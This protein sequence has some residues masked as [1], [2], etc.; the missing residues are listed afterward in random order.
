MNY[1]RAPYKIPK[2][3]NTTHNS[4]LSR[5]RKHCH[6]FLHASLVI[7]IMIVRAT[8]A[9]TLGKHCAKS[10]RLS[11]DEEGK[12]IERLNSTAF[13]IVSRRSFDNDC[14]SVEAF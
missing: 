11:V 3:F 9:H 10:I 7:I 8:A 2:L 14:E 13:D 6:R 12:K 4:R 1:C 5:A